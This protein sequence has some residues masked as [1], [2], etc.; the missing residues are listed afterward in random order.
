MNRI[1]N[2]ATRPDFR[3]GVAALP[4]TPEPGA[5]P[6][7]SPAGS[8]CTRLY[9]DSDSKNKEQAWEVFKYW[10]RPEKNAALRAVQRPRRLAPGQDRLRG[11]R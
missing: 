11:R 5:S 10:M 6:G 8:A 2:L 9:L 4:Y 7:T 3:W 1:C